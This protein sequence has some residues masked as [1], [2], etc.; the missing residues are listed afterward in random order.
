V[1]FPAL[2][3]GSTLVIESEVEVR[4]HYPS[5]ELVLLENEPVTELEVVVRGGGPGWRFHLEGPASGLTVEEL[6][7]G[8]RVRGRGLEGS[9]PPQLAPAAAWPVLRYA[10]DG[11]G[12]WHGVGRWYRQLL[13]PL[14]TGA[15]PVVAQ[16]LALTAGLGGPR[17]RLEAILAYLRHEVR[18]VAVEEGLG[19]VRPSPPEDVLQRRWGDCKD[20]S[21]LLVDLLRQAGIEA[22]PALASA[23]RRRHVDPRFPSPWSFNH[24]LV[25]VPQGAVATLA[26]DPVGDGFLFL[27]PTQSRGSGRWLAP[28]VQDQ[29][30]L[31]IRPGEAVLARTPLRPEL[32]HRRLTLEVRV[33]PD[34]ET[35][36]HVKLV[37]SGASAAR[38]LDEAA[39]AG[40]EGGKRVAHERLGRLLPGYVALELLSF[41]EEAGGG[42]PTVSLEAILRFHN[43]ARATATGFSLSP[44]GGTVMPDPRR[45]GDRRVPVVGEP[46][47]FESVWRFSLAGRRCRVRAAGQEVGNELGRFRQTVGTTPAGE[48]EMRRLGELYRRWI[49]PSEVPALVELAVAEHRAHRRLIRLD[50]DE[51]PSG[52]TDEARS[53]E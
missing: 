1:R 31:V 45:R 40:P 16:A 26:D 10:W 36:G 37:E 52:R 15:E 11:D 43:L 12:S 20:Q 2:A 23:G 21:V 4:P 13:D 24:M 18:Y 34:G 8:V 7:G 38:W 28:A 30:V 25:A 44:P 32:E 19:S 5:G 33:T 39:V 6:A 29:N 27:D 50:W 35:T 17:Q 49:E 41:G 9:D 42:V 3:V 14:P 47:S 53:R 51:V 22:Y 48:V 46:G